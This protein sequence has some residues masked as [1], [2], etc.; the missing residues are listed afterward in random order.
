[1]SD[2]NSGSKKRALEFAIGEAAGEIIVSSDADC[3]YNSNWL[4]SIC[5]KFDERTGFL[6]GPV[7][8]KASD[9]FLSKFQKIEFIGLNLSGAGLIGAGKPVIAS[10]ANAAFRKSVFRQIGGYGELHNFA[11]GDDELLMQKIKNETDY[12]IKFNFCAEGIVKTEA[13]STW[14]EFLEQRKRWASKGLFYKSK[15]LV[16]SLILIYLF[17]LLIPLNIVFG[18]I[19]SKTFFLIL[20]AQIIIKF[21]LEYLIM[22]YGCRKLFNKEVLKYFLPAQVIQIPYILISAFSGLS[23]GINWKGR[24]RKR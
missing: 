15:L 4:K 16:V 1:M 20:A 12:K 23:G 13:V 21:L 9:N 3:T 5:S 11:S 7:E 10:A 18:F 22:E 2:Q 17:Y 6:S 8:I 24:S 14:G 19:I